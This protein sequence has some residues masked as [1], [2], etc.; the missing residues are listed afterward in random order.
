M[1]RKK[2]VKKLKVKHP[3]KIKI[4][5]KISKPVLSDDSVLNVYGV[6]LYNQQLL[7][8]LIILLLILILLYLFL[9]TN[10]P[11]KNNF[12]AIPKWEPSGEQEIILMNAWNLEIFNLSEIKDYYYDR[13]DNAVYLFFTENFSVKSYGNLTSTLGNIRKS[14]LKNSSDDLQVFFC[15]NNFTKFVT[16][17]CYSEMW[18][19]GSVG[20]S[21]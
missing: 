5:T 15:E 14:V 7:F 19:N 6:R 10:K 11:D 16:K 3:R 8:I 4:E 1:S 9:F 21:S 13:Y 2:S 17:A 18:Y 12:S 20:F